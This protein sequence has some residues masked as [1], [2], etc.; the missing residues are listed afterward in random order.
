MIELTLT[1]I[2]SAMG[3]RV[4]LGSSD[5]NQTVSGDAQTDSRE[6]E[7]GQI[8]FARMGES[9]DGHRFAG[10]AIKRGAALLV[11]E[12][13]LGTSELEL[14][15]A[16]VAATPQIVVKDATVALGALARDVV[17]RVRASGNLTV[18]GITGSNGKTT[19]KNLVA[20]LAER[21]GPSVASIRSFNNEVGGPLTMLRVRQDTRTLV[22]E[23]GASAPGEIAR[24]TAMA[25]PHI[26]VV[27]SVGL[28]H[29]GEFG[30][31]E[32]TVQTKSEMVRDLEE[33]A[34]AI[35]NRDDPRV[36]QMAEMTR[37][38][39]RWFGLHEEADVRASDIRTSREGTEFTLHANGDSHPVKF[40]VL[41]EHHVS[42]ALAASAVG[43]ELGLELTDIV[44]SLESV[45]VAA[46]GRMQVLGGRDDIT[47]IN[48]AYNASPDSMTA[49]LRTLAQLGR[50][51]AKTVA[52]LG[53]MS[54]LGEL[55]G[56]EHDRIGLQAVRLGISQ[57]V[58]VG[59][60]ARRLH[61]SAINE[62]SWDGESVFFA[63]Q[64]AAFDYLTGSLRTGDTV[65][66][67][68]SNAAG[69]QALGD[70]LGEAYA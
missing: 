18:V 9:T 19:T 41:G 34:V 6:I 16:E 22:A 54:E 25:P 38:Q 23:M 60:A 68:S 30:S 39:V 65:L 61:I 20:K 53:A 11:V 33:D 62:G 21:L 1:D 48:D 59:D 58:V 47:I 36:A 4:I 49:A 64:D 26:G 3:G 45:T 7:A 66:V 8:F 51:G 67:K 52:V 40:R 24:L 12:R 28:A 27:L 69:L 10:Q 50:S 55:A 56:E 15:S 2:A 35:L 31:I 44:D 17:A 57:L 46:P 37:A 70:R 13:E 43:L 42:N 32:S 63:D 14:S 5:P 29:A